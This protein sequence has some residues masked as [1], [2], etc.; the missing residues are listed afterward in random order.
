[1]SRRTLI[2]RLAD[3]GYRPLEKKHKSDVSTALAKR[4]MAFALRYKGWTKAQWKSEVDAVGDIKTFTWYPKSLYPRFKRYRATWTYMTEKERN[5]AAFQRPKR[6]FPKKD[7]V[8]TKGQKIFGMTTSNGKIL[9]I[10]M[11]TP[12]NN[13]IWKR[14][15]TSKIV[16]FLK[17]AFPNKRAFKLLLDGEK[18]FHAPEP[19]A[20][21]REAGI[22]ILPGWPAYSPE[23]NPQENVWPQSDKR[24]RQLEGNGGQ[25]FERFGDMAVQAVRQYNGAKNLIGSMVGKIEECIESKGQFVDS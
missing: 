23:L 7:W 22:T 11:P 19:K 20:A 1:M 12:Y 13:Y 16:P 3:K 6:W 2:R 18:I 5:K 24:L 10:K 14:L 8:K 17:R 25:T 4:R 9:A 21:Y 15:V